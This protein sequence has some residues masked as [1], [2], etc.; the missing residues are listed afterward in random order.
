M[1][2]GGPLLAVS[3]AITIDAKIFQLVAMCFKISPLVS[4]QWLSTIKL[5]KVIVLIIIPVLFDFFRQEG[6]WQ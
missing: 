6:L 1:V 3:W 4:I 5:F 2:L